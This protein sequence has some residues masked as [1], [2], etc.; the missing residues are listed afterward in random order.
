MELVFDI[1]VEPV[2]PAL[3]AGFLT[4]REAWCFDF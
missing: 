1:G 3:A 4:T 2:S